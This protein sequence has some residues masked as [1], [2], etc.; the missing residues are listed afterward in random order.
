VTSEEVERAKAICA[1]AVGTSLEMP[2]MVS[3][4]IGRQIVTYGRRMSLKDFK[5]MLHVRSSERHFLEL[6]CL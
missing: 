5:K 1:S 6:A 3:E 2:L 4:D